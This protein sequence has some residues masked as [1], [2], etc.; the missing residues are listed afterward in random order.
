MFNSRHG[1]AGQKPRR[2]YSLGRTTDIHSAAS[3]SISE[4]Q[5]YHSTTQLQNPGSQLDM[6]YQHVVTM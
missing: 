4:L 1:A 2:I 3:F 5:G 6:M